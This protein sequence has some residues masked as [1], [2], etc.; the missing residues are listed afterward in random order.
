MLSCGWPPPDAVIA[1]GAITA[2]GAWS[3]YWATASAVFFAQYAFT[4]LGAVASPPHCA[5][6]ECAG[7]VWDVNDTVSTPAL[8]PR[9]PLIP[10]GVRLRRSGSPNVVTPS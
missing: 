6:C 2:L 3:L 4:G 7:S 1:S 5:R 10:I 9:L 8:A